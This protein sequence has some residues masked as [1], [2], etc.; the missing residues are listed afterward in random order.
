MKIQIVIPLYKRPEVTRVCFD[1]LKAMIEAVT[2]HEFSVLCVSDEI[3]YYEMCQSYGFEHIAFKND[4]LGEKINFAIKWALERNE[5]DYLMTMNSDSV[6]SPDLFFEYYDSFFGN[7]VFGVSRVTY[8]NFYT[9]E[10]VDFEYHF[11]L[12]GV[13]RCMSRQ[14]VKR[15]FDEI[16]EVYESFRNK[17]L[18][19]SVLSNLRQVNV[20]PMFIQYKGQMV[21]DLKSD[22]NIHPWEKFA[23]KGVKVE[24][25]L[26]YKAG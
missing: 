2:H 25:Q 9:D 18:D 7:D 13:A 23:D 5:W 3:E 1:Y 16:G 19:D 11:S 22:V 24:N 21:Y 20:R 8:V 17:G 14:L 15:M 4:P 12:L 6:I 26:C 10:A